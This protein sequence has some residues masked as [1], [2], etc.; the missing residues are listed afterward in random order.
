MAKSMRR[1]LK[2]ID[3]TKG[4]KVVFSSEEPM[5]TQSEYLGSI[6]FV[7]SVS[8]LLMASEIVKD[9]LES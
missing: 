3:I 4:L 1:R 5:P 2:Q 6:A 8:G 9:I 7:P